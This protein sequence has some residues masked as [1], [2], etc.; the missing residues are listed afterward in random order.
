MFDKLIL[1]LYNLLYKRG[2]ARVKK[3]TQMAS[4]GYENVAGQ[5]EIS[6]Q[7][8]TFAIPKTS[9]KTAQVFVNNNFE[10]DSSQDVERTASKTIATIKQKQIDKYD[11]LESY[12]NLLKKRNKRLV[13]RIFTFILLLIIAP[14]MIFWGTVILDKNGRHDFF[15]YNLY[16]VISESMEPDIMVND[17]VILKKVD[18]IDSLAVG[19]YVGYINSQGKIVVHQ[20]VLIRENINGI[21]EFETKGINNISSDQ[22]RVGFEQIV[23]KHVKTIGWLGNLIVFFRSTVGLILFIVLFICAMLGFFLAFRL[24]E[25]ITYIENVEK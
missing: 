8:R 17:C 5:L 2:D 23:G 6:K 21:T 13:A 18:D 3:T 9:T 12:K 1:Q 7:Y 20:I 10:I 24:S 19:D 11:E 15:G 4:I 14:V 22:M 16:V 25:N